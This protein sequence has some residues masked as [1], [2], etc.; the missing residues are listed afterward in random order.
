MAREVP[1]A[2]QLLS[3]QRWRTTVGLVLVITLIAFEAMAVATVLPV[4]AD[5]LGGLRLYGWA[6][7]AFLLTQLLGI[8]IAG[9]ALDHR[10]PAVPMLAGVVTFAGGLLVA[11]LAPSM[12]VLVAGRAVQGLGAG[13][14]GAAV[15]AVMAIGYD[16]AVRPRLMAVT[17]TAWVVPA[18]VGPG[19]AGVV[20]EHLGWRLAFLGIL[21]LTVPVLLMLGPG[22]RSMTPTDP[23]DVS[24]PRSRRRH[25][26]AVALLAGVAL[27]MVAGQPGTVWVRVVEAVAGL[28]VV[29]P[30]LRVLLPVG[31]FRLTAG[32]PAAIAVR[33]VMTMTFFG[34]EAFL[35]L[36][37]TDVRGLSAGEAGLALTCGAIGWAIGSWV[38]ER[39]DG[40]VPRP[41]LVRVGLLVLAAGVAG[42]ALG[43]QPWLPS[44]IGA[45]A[46]GVGGAGM[47]LAFSSVALVVIAGAPQGEQGRTMAGLQT[48]DV[49]GGLL[50]TG[51]GGAI[52]AAANAPTVTGGRIATI[53]VLLA[54]V[55]IGGAAAAGRLAERD[56]GSEAGDKGWS[57][58]EQRHTFDT[59]GFG[60]R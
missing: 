35:P 10:G 40:A 58:R 32:V 26:S 34:A 56:G 8:V 37:L 45:I 12:E 48:A 7:S 17:S 3:P 42:A 2:E 29:V 16:D 24:T 1:P 18:L 21:P 41:T 50:G 31:T 11:G 5:E 51:L 39:R 44:F 28:A 49:I 52:V 43:L 60:G 14:M 59:G 57:V 9:E 13:A 20:A 22:L 36:G 27:L 54:A 19:V 38:Q 23:P 53:Y 15:Y 33:G 25:R 46:W 30:A 55:A 47:G 6:F 4:A